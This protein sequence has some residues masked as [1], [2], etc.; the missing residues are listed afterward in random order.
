MGAK[1]LMKYLASFSSACLETFTVT[2]HVGPR[3]GPG[4]PLLPYRLAFAVADSP[5]WAVQ[6]RGVLPTKEA[7]HS[8]ITTRGRLVKRGRG[9][10]T[11]TFAAKIEVS[12]DCGEVTH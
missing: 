11:G 7:I 1:P 8:T 3:G 6:R 4:L 12:A 2:A 10:N 5:H 9:K